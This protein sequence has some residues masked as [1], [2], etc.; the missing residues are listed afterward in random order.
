MKCIYHNAFF[1]H[2]VQVYVV[3]ILS[4]FHHYWLDLERSGL[5]LRKGGEEGWPSLLK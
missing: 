2:V 4:A 1:G 3:H 5:I